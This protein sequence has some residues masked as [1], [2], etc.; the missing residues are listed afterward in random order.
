[1]KANPSEE[2]SFYTQGQQFAARVLFTA[3]LLASVS[4]EGTLATPKRQAAMTPATTTSPG[5]L[6][7]ASTPSTPPP[8]GILQL[9]PD[10][11]GSFWGG[12]VASSPS[13]DAAPQHQ[14]AASLRA[15]TIDKL[16]G[17]L[18]RP[19]TQE[20]PR[21][22]GWTCGRKATRQAP[23]AASTQQWTLETL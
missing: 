12:S 2:R 19:R 10:S 17:R 9:P 4:P 8:G 21:N 6:S 14:P 15:R 13:I 16:V 5:G 3:W 23:A 11:P 20:T 7:L 1:M 18:W 22:S